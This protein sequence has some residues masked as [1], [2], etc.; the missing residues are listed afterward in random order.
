MTS[1][2]R[3]WVFLNDEMTN[4]KP[5]R[6]RS[7]HS[8]KPSR[9]RQY[10]EAKFP[11]LGRRSRSK[12]S[13]RQ[14]P[15]NESGLV[16]TLVEGARTD[17]LQSPPSNDNVSR[18]NTAPPHSYVLSPSDHSLWEDAIANIRNSKKDPQL[19]AFVEELGSQ[20]TQGL[21]PNDIVH[22]IAAMI[23]GEVKRGA[24]D[25]Y[26]VK[27]FISGFVEQ[28]VSVINSFLA[29]G[30]VAVSFDPVHA[31]LPWAAVR[32]VLVALVSSK[33]LKERLIGGIAATSSLIL[34]CES[35]R[36]L[37][38]DSEPDLRPPEHALCK[39][40]DC[41]LQAYHSSLMFLGFA[42]RCQ[43][44]S[45]SKHLKAVFRLEDMDN[46]VKNVLDSGRALE[47]IADLCERHCDHLSRGKISSLHGIAQSSY[48]AL[49]LLRDQRPILLNIQQ[50][51]ILSK[52]RIAEDAAFD[53]FT[54]TSEV[55]CH[56]ETRVAL[57]QEMVEWASDPDS[58]TIFWLQG[59]AGTGKSTVSR[60]FA[61]KLQMMGALGASF[62]FKRGDGDRGIARLF[63]PT[64]ATQLAQ[65]VSAF[66]WSL[67]ERVER[68]PDIGNKSMEL[69]FDKLL[70]QPLQTLGHPESSTFIIVID[71]LDECDPEIHATTI[72]RLLSRLKQGK[73]SS[74]RLKFFV[75]SRPEFPIRLEFDKIK[76]TYKDLALHHIHDDVI[77][78]DMEVYLDFELQ[79]IRENYN[80]LQ[81]LD[82]RLAPDWPG[83]DRIRLLVRQAVPLFIFART[84]CLFIGDTYS[85]PEDQ[86]RRVLEAQN[87][88]H[89]SQLQKTYLLVLD[90]LL[91]EHS[92]SGLVECNEDKKRI[93]LESFR[94][95][96]GSLV[97]LAYPLPLESLARLLKVPK[98]NIRDRLNSLHSVLDVP[99][100]HNHASPVKI[101]HLSFRD[102]LIDPKNQKISRFWID[103]KETHAVLAAKCVDFLMEDGVLKKDICDLIYPG[104]M[105][106]KISQK[107]VE[108]RLPPAVQYSCLY[109][110]H[111][112]KA[113][114]KQ[115]DDTG[116][117]YTFL[118]KKFLFWLEALAIMDR[119]TEGLLVIE[120]L[121]DITNDTNAR[122]TLEYLEDAKRFILYSRKEIQ[123]NPLG[124]YTFGLVFAPKGSIVRKSFSHLLPSSLK[125]LEQPDHWSQRLY[126]NLP[127]DERVQNLIF[128]ANGRFVACCSPNMVNVWDM[129]AG[130]HYPC[131]QLQGSSFQ[132]AA[133]LRR[134]VH[135]RPSKHRRR[136]LC[137]CL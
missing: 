48:E 43:Q 44:D 90:R 20:N 107:L 63:F 53:H 55:E 49:E 2:L 130:Q 85:N 33:E 92:D 132:P 96:V 65:Q 105:K 135:G 74:L 78:C 75:T 125:V 117:V 40:R 81:A 88:D 124:V 126:L 31:A 7:V 27:S 123:F 108:E 87:V 58:H 136:S 113:S 19:V 115:I 70:L 101:L 37:Y 98:R 131:I 52:L 95:I 17:R 89:G 10:L 42:H 38:I 13:L 100:I 32:F 94:E 11:L 59:M 116:T 121:L 62:F 56:P 61:R 76:G 103:E 50:D 41:I 35:Y 137:H 8:P 129:T 34:Q 120:S 112:V 18:P 106:H 64:I 45:S 72:I 26:A 71:A 93:V 1:E 84:A 15:S 51:L 134:K 119:I 102:F 25:Q 24:E 104:T 54:K 79:R 110:A 14:F 128:S 3:T 57:L 127:Y 23:Q 5:Q 9:V 109:W 82:D 99:G 97:L 30:D 28:T 77:T 60:T 86:L 91:L 21:S 69:Q 133:F 29:V 66:G 114:N 22:T 46:H 118:K 39:L 68:E 12:S 36:I 67:K 6:S 73:G 80:R 16:S 47:R 83:Q 111:H 4:D 122:R